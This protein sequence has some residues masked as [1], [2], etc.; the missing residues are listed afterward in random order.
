MKSVKLIS[1]LILATSLIFLSGCL[2]KQKTADAPVETNNI[3]QPS[4]QKQQ[5]ITVWIH[6]TRLV[7]QFAPQELFFS[8]DGIKNSLE[9][10]WYYHGH[11]LAKNISTNDPERFQMENFYFF[12]WNG[13]LS[14]EERER[15]AKDLYKHLVN[16]TKQYTKKHGIAPQ[17]RIITHSHGG[18][19]A[20]NLAKV[21]EKDTPFIVSELILLACPVQEKTTPFI[22]DPLFKRVYSFFSRGEFLQVVDP[23]GLYKTSEKTPL[24]SKRLF[25]DQPNLSQAQIKMHGRSILHAEFLFGHFAYRIPELLNALDKDHLAINKQKNKNGPDYVLIDLKKKQ[26]HKQDNKRVRK[27]ILT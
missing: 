10:P 5:T 2:H 18:N 24:F 22:A 3:V 9:L 26:M 14:F 1:S 16:L 6:G 12:G 19:V 20:L 15:A 25:P 13:K 23:Q 7:S 11:R 21:K 4:E 27:I 8:P 17:F